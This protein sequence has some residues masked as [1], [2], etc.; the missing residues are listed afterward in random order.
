MSTPPRAIQIP[1]VDVSIPPDAILAPDAP[2][3]DKPVPVGSVIPPTAPT[4]EDFLSAVR[5]VNEKKLENSPTGHPPST[6]PKTEEKPKHDT[7]PDVFKT[8]NSTSDSEPDTTD[9]TDTSLDDEF[10]DPLDNEPVKA[11]KAKSIKDLRNQLKTVR[12]RETQLRTR[13]EELESENQRL[14]A[15]QEKIDEHETLKQ[16]V[17]ELETYE[18][19]FDIHNNPQFNEKYVQGEENLTN[20]AK[21]LTSHYKVN[22]QVIDHALTID[23]SDRK[24]LNDFLKKSGLDEYGVPEVRQYIL[25][26]QGL[27]AERSELEKSPQ[28]AREILGRMYRE[29]EVRRV[30]TV[31]KAVKDR[32]TH[33]WNGVIGYYSRGENALDI[34]KDKPGDPEHTEVRNNVLTRA[35]V[36][37]NKVMGAFVGLGIKDIPVAVAQT[38]AARF[39]LSEAAGELN[40][41][42]KILRQQVKDLQDQLDKE[43]KY[44][45]PAFQG[46]RN[47]S[48]ASGDSELPKGTDVASHVFNKAISA[49]TSRTTR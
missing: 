23:P 32:G 7:T 19:I 6:V 31:T 40:A 27:R 13:V 14:A 37:Y 2:M 28:E 12:G 10:A 34:F 47:G 3:T 39:Q 9:D 22:P 26:I 44:T 43:K 1:K 24:A 25:R 30:E 35:N 36:E 42:N 4:T 29:G 15:F 46:S 17:E 49:D 41:D 48:N 5:E 16:R 21:V 33:A 8:D 20:E 11:P 45:R 18:Q 38:L